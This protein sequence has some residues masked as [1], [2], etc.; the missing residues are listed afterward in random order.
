M[1]FLWLRV[2][3]SSQT[4]QCDEGK[5]IQPQARAVDKHGTTWTMYTCHA[6]PPQPLDE[7]TGQG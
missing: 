6:F 4:L 7:V 5:Q 3:T 2:A 1:M